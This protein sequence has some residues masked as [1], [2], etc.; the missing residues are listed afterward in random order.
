MGDSGKLLLLLTR[1]SGLLEWEQKVDL[2]GANSK[3]LV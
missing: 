2:N 3:L 1:V